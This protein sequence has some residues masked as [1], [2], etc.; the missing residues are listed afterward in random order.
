MISC[1]NR[2]YTENFALSKRHS[3]PNRCHF[4]RKL[5][6]KVPIYKQFGVNCV[7]IL[8]S[9]NVIEQIILKVNKIHLLST[10]ICYNT[11][12]KTNVKRILQ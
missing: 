11:L 3:H 2:I 12:Y 7:F 9:S 1:N 6:T 8:C 10:I 4:L 5:P